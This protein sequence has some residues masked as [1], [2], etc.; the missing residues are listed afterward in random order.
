MVRQG[1]PAHW[2]LLSLGATLL[3][4]ATAVAGDLWLEHVTIVSPERPQPLPNASVQIH[5][6]RIVSVSQGTVSRRLKDAEDGEV[7]DG[8]GL[9]LAP[10]LID[11]HVHLADVPGMGPEQEQAHPDL[12]HATREQM[13]R[14]FLS[15]GFTTLIDLSSTPERMAAW[16]AHE[17]H[18]DTFFCGGV[19]V[20]DGYPTQWTPKPARY[21]AN[22]YFVV[23][24][25]D[26]STLPADIDSAVH[27][28]EAV[29]SRMKADGAICVKSYFERG[30]GADRNLPVP[31]L[32]TMRALVRA[33]HAA[34]L[35]LLFHANSSEAQAFG[36]EAGVDIFAHALWN[37]S[38]AGPATAVTPGVKKILD[39]VLAAQLGW[40]PTIQVLYGE[41]DLFDPALLSNPLLA[42]ALPASLI[43]WYGTSEGQWFR[44]VMMQSALPKAEAQ[45]NDRERQWKAVRSEYATVIARATNATAYLAQHDAKFMFGTDTP[46]G[47]TYAN[48]PGLNG[49]REMQNLLD[50]GLTPAQVFQAAT[51]TNARVMGLSATLGTV[52]AGKRANLLLLREDPSRTIKAYAGIVK[53]ILG[54]RVLDPAELAANTRKGVH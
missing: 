40:Q 38:D 35:P 50:A 18:P 30:F 47:P 29:V 23:Q 8:T 19:P 34:G 33:A 32:A 42:R 4:S 20:V 6:D 12:A 41:R 5:E 26:P 21:Y 49:W 22:P 15:F 2:L 17:I 28:P 25:G 24:A 45:S 13:P 27:S 48:P 53:V 16:N 52:E 36:L 37:W 51:L 1:F 44:D 46:S 10:G 39:G 3:Y 14:S 31:T 7:I 9:Y 43:A 54:G 11:S